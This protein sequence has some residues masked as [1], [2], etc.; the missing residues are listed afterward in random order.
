MTDGYGSISFWGYSPSLDLLQTE[1]EEKVLTTNIRDDSDKPDTI[2]ILLVGAADIRHVLKTIICANLHPKKKLHFH[3]F[4]NRL[5]LYA[6]HMLLLAIAL[7]PYKQVGLQDKV[8][9][10]LELY[11]NSLVRTKSFEYLQKMSNE[12]IRMV[13]DFDYLEK[14]LP[15]LDMTRL[16]FKERDFLEGIFKFWRNP[17]QKLFDISKC[18]DVRVQGYLKTRYD[19]KMNAFDWD[20]HMKLAERQADIINRNE[21]AKW[22]STG[23]AFENRDGEY[24]VPN[25]SLASGMI[26]SRG[27]ERINVRGYW[28]DILVSPFVAM[29]IEADLPELF[30]KFNGAYHKTARH[31]TTYNVTSMFHTLITGEKYLPSKVEE[32]ENQTSSVIEEIEDD[33]SSMEFKTTDDK[34]MPQSENKEYQSIPVDT[35]K[36]TFLPL[37]ACITMPKKSNYQCFFDTVYF[38]NTSVHHLLPEMT[39]IFSD[40]TTV[41]IETA[42]FMVDLKK[43]KTNEYV[44][45][46]TERAV[47]TGCEVSIKLNIRLD[48]VLSNFSL[49]IS[50]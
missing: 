12:F 36:L 25:T 42:K 48:Q 26:L 14:K 16:K 31:V 17:D 9:L 21:Y 47:K 6:R 11:G 45:K 8:E 41:L 43:E 46:I 2:N 39:P 7:E 30:K 1:H 38:S 44:T 15:C 13:T 49:F 20:Y 50:G 5:E 23:V 18:W 22:R 32:T 19:T 40:K 27:G 3:I 4:E 37:D 10:F 33:D 28:G 34:T 29:G 35:F 24:T